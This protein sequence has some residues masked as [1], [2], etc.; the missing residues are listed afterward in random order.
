M[1]PKGWGAKFNHGFN[2]GFERFLDAYH[3]CVTRTVARPLTTLGLFAGIFAASLLI[4]PLLG[5]AFFPSTDAGQ[6]VI[7]VKS[8]S[9]TRLEET[10]NDIEKLEALIR[11]TVPEHELGMI[12]SNI[13]VD[14]GFSAIFTSNSAMHTSYVQ[15]ALKPDHRTGSYEY[16]ARVKKAMEEELPQL[17]PYFGSGSLVESTLNMGFAAPDRYTD[18]R[19]RHGG[20][21]QTRAGFREED[22]AHSRTWGTCSSRRIWTSRLSSWTST[23]CARAN[24]GSVRRKWFRT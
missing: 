22:P 6:F 4:V 18:L 10:E 1:P 14:P 12:V 8:P 17:T 2:R 9:G 7:R 24:S 3:R 13:G 23:G 11:R 20:E 19:V 5:L 16:I 21:L 15:V